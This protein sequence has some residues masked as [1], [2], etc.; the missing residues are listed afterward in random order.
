MVKHVVTFKFSGTTE[1][2]AKVA[3]EFKAALEDMVGKV[4]VLQAIEVGIN[5]NPNETWDLV[6]TATLATM[7]DV[8]LYAKHP[9]HVAATQIIAKNKQM[10]ACVDYV[11]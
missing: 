11:I 1:E 9:L 7:A 3:A 2:R 6:L 4:G 5:Q 10:R 8:P